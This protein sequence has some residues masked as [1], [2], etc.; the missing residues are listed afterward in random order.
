MFKNKILLALCLF[1][2]GG[3]TNLRAMQ[4][5]AKQAGVSAGLGA[6][7]KS[8]ASS[9][10]KVIGTAT[11]F[12]II[13]SIIW[14]RAQNREG[15]LRG[16]LNEYRAMGEVTAIRA[17]NAVQ[18]GVDKAAKAVRKAFG[19]AEDATD[20]TPDQA[21]DTALKS[22]NMIDRTIVKMVRGLKKGAN[23]FGK[24]ARAGEQQ[25]REQIA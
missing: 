18:N 14:L 8:N 25:V 15:Y 19:K 20:Q 23:W 9:H 22:L 13:L 5:A 11:V 16:K 2:I 24:K 17:E 3:A 1:L 7:I 21:Q 4:D 12:A 6:F 10:A